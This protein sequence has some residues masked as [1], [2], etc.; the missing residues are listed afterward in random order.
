[1]AEKTL[2]ARPEYGWGEMLQGWFTEDEVLV[3]NHAK[4]GR[5]TKSFIDEGRWEALLSGVN[6]GDFVFI[7]FGHND[8]KEQSPERYAPP[9]AYKANLERF[10]NDVI[11][12]NATPVLLT[13]VVRRRFDENGVFYDT[14]GVYPG[15]VKQVADGTDTALIDLHTRS[16]LHLQAYGAERSKELY[17]WLQPGQSV[18]HPD[19]VEDDTHF[20]QLGARTMASLVMQGIQAELPSLEKHLQYLPGG[21]Q[22]DSEVAQTDG[23]PH[24]GGGT[25][26]GHWFFKDY[27]QP[28]FAFKK[29]TLYPDSSIGYHLHDK[30]EV[31]YVLE[32]SGELVF[33]GKKSTVGPGTAILTRPGDSHGLK[34]AAGGD[35]TIIIV[36][37]IRND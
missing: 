24:D 23:G 2:E 32:G 17:L 19:G 30:D 15:L 21:I 33:N 10:V 13:P 22:Q 34:P 25:T 3:L 20:S 26:L 1:M 16:M 28:R 37:E 14:H 8:P 27:A 5:S 31:Y 35:L 6:P 11:A 36:Y 29:R 7:Q 12:R 4:N 18:K 9:P